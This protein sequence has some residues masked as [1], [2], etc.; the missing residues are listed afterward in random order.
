MV[1]EGFAAGTRDPR[2]Q[3]RRRLYEHHQ[4]GA[5]WLVDGATDISVALSYEM[6]G[7]WRDENARD[8]EALNQ[9]GKPSS[10]SQAVLLMF[11]GWQTL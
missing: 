7:R 6:S 3:R 11:L 4:Y 2:R 9:A 5:R 10:S 1:A 8:A